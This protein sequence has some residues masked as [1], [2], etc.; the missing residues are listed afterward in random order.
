MTESRFRQWSVVMAGAAV[1]IVVGAALLMP[2][3]SVQQAV[4]REL[5]EQELADVTAVVREQTTERIR[6][7]RIDRDGTVLVFVSDGLGRREFRVGKV[8][9]R[10]RVVGVTLCFFA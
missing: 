7:V 3:G 1:L 6:G 8:E 2:R 4:P 5:T 10:W 9:G